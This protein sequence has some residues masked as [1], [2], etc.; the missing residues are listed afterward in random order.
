MSFIDHPL[1]SRVVSE[2]HMRRVPAL[3]APTLMIQVVRLVD[4]LERKLERA[5]AKRMPGVAAHNLLERNRHI[6]AHRGD[7]VEFL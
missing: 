7:G 2:M 6:G 1:R 3:I 4:P 5:Q